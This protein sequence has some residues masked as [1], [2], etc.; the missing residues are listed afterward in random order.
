MPQ[1][2]IN[3]YSSQLF[4]FLISFAILYLAFHF[5]II[6]RIDSILS[7]RR[8]KIEADDN[9]NKDLTSKISALRIKSD[10]ILRE[11][12]QSYQSQL[13]ET[14]D[15]INKDKEQHVS[16]LKKRFELMFEES[17][18]KIKEN[19][20]QSVERGKVIVEDLSNMILST[21]LLK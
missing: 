7:K 6:P 2:D 12:S 15:K 10:E 14:L 5:L 21:I 1:F 18:Q 3:T 4:W 19:E 9:A 16:S 11:A 20:D 8:E 17:R 13:N